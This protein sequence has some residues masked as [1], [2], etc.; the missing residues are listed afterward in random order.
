MLGQSFPP[1]T[2]IQVPKLPL[3]AICKR[4]AIAIASY[5]SSNHLLDSDLWTKL[6]LSITD[7][8]SQTSQENKT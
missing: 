3:D 8:K 5:V 1:P 2:H 7:N 4:L 6:N